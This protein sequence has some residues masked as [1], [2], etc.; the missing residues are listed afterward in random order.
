M[1]YPHVD[2]WDGVTRDQIVLMMEA[3]YEKERREWIRSVSIMNGLDDPSEALPRWTVNPHVT[4]LKT[5]IEPF[6]F[7]LSAQRGIVE[8]V[9]RGLVV[10]DVWADQVL[11]M[12]EHLLAATG[13][14]QTW[15]QK[16]ME[17]LTRGRASKRWQTK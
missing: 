5:P 1:H 8:A 4:R 12:W 11:P 14:L 9:E 6:D 3:V 7:S 13:D 15:R 10:G 2:F 17:S 16:E